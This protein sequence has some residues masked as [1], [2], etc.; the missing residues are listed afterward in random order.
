MIMS[1]QI[2]YMSVQKLLFDKL[3][4]QLKKLLLPLIRGFLKLRVL[5]RVLY[6]I[7]GVS[8]NLLS[9][10]TSSLSLNLSGVVYGLAVAVML[11]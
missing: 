9:I 3:S 4:G 8:P 10:S 1:V 11:E 7:V 2:M 6:G 5:L